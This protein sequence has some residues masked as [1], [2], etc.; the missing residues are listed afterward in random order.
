M[1]TG[2]N[3]IGYTVSGKGSNVFSYP[4]PENGDSPVYSFTEASPEEIDTACIL[5]DKAFS[6]YRFST[7]HQKISFL[8]KIAEAIAISKDELVKMAMAETH[9]AKPRLEGE[10]QR[11]INQIKLFAAMLAE[12]SWVNAVIDTAQPDRAPL[13][14]PDIRQ[15]QVPLGPVAVFGASNFPFAFSVA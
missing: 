14:K 10:V 15:M 5:A 2:K 9:L 7:P 4:L 11:T 1:I 3:L 13:P 8:E 6:T 12:G